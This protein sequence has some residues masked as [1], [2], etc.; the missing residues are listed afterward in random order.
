MKWKHV[1][2]SLD[3]AMKALRKTKFYSETDFFIQLK[4]FFIINVYYLLG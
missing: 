2:F 4:A 1:N 3:Q